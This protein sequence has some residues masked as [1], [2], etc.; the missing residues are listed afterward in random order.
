MAAADPL[1]SDLAFSASAQQTIELALGSPVTLAREPLETA[2]IE[3]RDDPTTVADEPGWLQSTGRTR[4]ASPLTPNIIARNSCVGRNSS[5]CMR[6]R[7]I[8]IQRQH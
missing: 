4:D 1:I 8:S 6:S 5:V 3:N 7:V 2:T